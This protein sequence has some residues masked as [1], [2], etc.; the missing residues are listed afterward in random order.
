MLKGQGTLDLVLRKGSGIDLFPGE[1][2]GYSSASSTTD[3]TSNHSNNNKK[4][5]EGGKRINHVIE[6]ERYSIPSRRPGEK[7]A[8]PVPVPPPC[9]P[10]PPPLK[11]SSSVD[12]ILD[13]LKTAG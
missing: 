7:R 11:S 13:E 5:T 10:R 9:V 2:S 8:A 1:S 3:E 6:D 4:F 12:N